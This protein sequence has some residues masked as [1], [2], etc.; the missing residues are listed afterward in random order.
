MK[1]EEFRK[2]FFKQIRLNAQYFKPKEIKTLHD[3]AET[4]AEKD[5][6]EIK[7][8][9]IMKEEHR[10]ILAK[11]TKLCENHPQQRFCQ[12]LF[13]YTMIGTR[14]EQLGLVKDPFYYQDKDFI[15]SIEK[16]GD[17]DGKEIHK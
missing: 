17:C 10:E 7:G 11:L 2:E 3:F 6:V 12:I 1:Y 15:N 4:I 9:W 16:K 14:F 5:F 8:D 13:N